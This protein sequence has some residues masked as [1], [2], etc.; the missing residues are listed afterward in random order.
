MK[1][2]WIFFENEVIGEEYLN[3]EISVLFLSH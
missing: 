2:F 3:D 1:H